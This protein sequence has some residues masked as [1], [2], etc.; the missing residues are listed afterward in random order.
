MPDQMLR[1]TFFAFEVNGQDVRD[2]GI[3][4]AILDCPRLHLDAWVPPGAPVLGTK[5]EEW[6]VLFSEKQ[7]RIAILRNPSP[8]AANSWGPERYTSEDKTDWL[9]LTWHTLYNLEAR[10][11]V[12]GQ[13]I[14]A[15]LVRVGADE[16]R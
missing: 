5:F 10:G 2:Q 3:Y 9:D 16:G 12:G 14:D 6:A 4:L 7:G 11:V 8:Q 13:Q 15:R 1:S